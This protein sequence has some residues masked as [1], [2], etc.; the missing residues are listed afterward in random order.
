MNAQ[1]KAAYL[2]ARA[3]NRDPRKQGSKNKEL[4]HHYFGREIFGPEEE[5]EYQRELN[6]LHESLL[7][8]HHGIQA[9]KATIERFHADLS[10]MEQYWKQTQYLLG[11]HSRIGL[12]LQITKDHI[13]RFQAVN[14]ALMEKT[15]RAEAVRLNHQAPSPELWK[16]H[17]QKLKR[18][19]ELDAEESKA[20]QRVEE[21]E[22]L[23]IVFGEQAQDTPG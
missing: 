8:Q 13:Q 1:H 3:N 11:C 20:K 5:A 14:A 19:R 12:N 17:T 22:F 21:K 15:E 7:S 6:K 4:G 23:G 18:C 2:E 10:Q 9:L 16:M